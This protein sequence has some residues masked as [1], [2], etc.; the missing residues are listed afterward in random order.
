MF[1]RA[2][3]ILLTL[4][5]VGS[6]ALAVATHQMPLIYWPNDATVPCWW[7]LYTA[8]ADRGHFRIAFISYEKWQ[9][10][11]QKELERR[12]AE[13]GLLWHSI[14]HMPSPWTWGDWL[15]YYGFYVKWSIATTYSTA[16]EGGRAVEVKAKRREIGLGLPA[17]FVCVVA[18]AYPT[19]TFIRG[20]LRR[21]YSRRFRRE[22]GLCERCAYDL[23]GNTSGVCPEC[24]TTIRAVEA[25][26]L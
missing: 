14:P 15:R 5:A 16:Y 22:R 13:A 12:E 7:K 23:T 8:Q 1:R 2:I 24:G 3:L 6:A 26:S 21:R 9:P 10:L 18:G 25:A 17:W 19:I 4:T 20:P 11:S